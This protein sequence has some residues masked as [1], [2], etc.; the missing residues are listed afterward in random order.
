MY[1]F[2]CFLFVFFLFVCF[3]MDI[4][5]FEKGCSTLK[6][7]ESEESVGEGRVVCHDG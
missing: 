7:C 6:V 4:E 1:L 2:F 3:L 5:L